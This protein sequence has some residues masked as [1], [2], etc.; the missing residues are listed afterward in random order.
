MKIKEVELH[1]GFR[2]NIL[3]PPHWV[4]TTLLMFFLVSFVGLFFYWKIG[5]LGLTFSIFGLWLANKTGNEL[6]LQTIGQVAQKMTREDYL[7]SRRNSKTFNKKEIETILKDWFC[8]DLELDRNKLK[9][10][11][12]FV[13]NGD[14]IRITNGDDESV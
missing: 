11:T 5:V 1:L 12:K 8:N 13:G 7:K 2:L 4:T 10:E 14:K 9:R 6:E 3:R